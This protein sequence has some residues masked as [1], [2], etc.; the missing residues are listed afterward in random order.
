MKLITARFKMTAKDG[1]QSYESMDF[2]TVRHAEQWFESMVLALKMQPVGSK[3][4]VTE[5][6]IELGPLL[7]TKR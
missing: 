5:F 6:Y 2:L 7:S 1:T 4:S 3:A